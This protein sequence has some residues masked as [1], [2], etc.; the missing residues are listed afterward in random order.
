MEPL[1]L[2]PQDPLVY[3]VLSQLNTVYTLPL[4]F[5]IE[6]LYAGLIYSICIV[7]SE[8]YKLRTSIFGTFRPQIK[9]SLYKKCDYLYK[10][11]QFSLGRKNVNWVEEHS[12]YSYHWYAHGSWHANRIESSQTES[13]TR[14]GTAKADLQLHSTELD[15]GGV[16]ELYSNAHAKQT[17]LP[18][19]LLSEA[20]LI[21]IDSVSVHT[22]IPTP[23]A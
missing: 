6:I 23:V 22:G 12:V 1:S 3:S 20:D 8:T 17:S 5:S 14:Q 16:T 7:I 11:T 10:P 21:R 4:G 13:K 18:L 15:W 9:G 19:H 2:C